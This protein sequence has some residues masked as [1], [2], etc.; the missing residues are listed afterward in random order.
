MADTIHIKPSGRHIGGNDDAQCAILELLDGALTLRLH[1]V[2][3]QCGC[4]IS[5]GLELFGKCN[6]FGFGAYENDNAVERLGFENARQGIEFVVTTNH[7][8]ALADGINR[9]A[10]CLNR[11]L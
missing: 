3:V 6:G 7:P 4:R 5:P 2:A 1:H 9:R 8:V 11:D 10:L